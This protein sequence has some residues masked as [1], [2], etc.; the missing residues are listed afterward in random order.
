M[1]KA[2]AGRYLDCRALGTASSSAKRTVRSTAVTSP[3]LTSNLLRLAVGGSNDLM[4]QTYSYEAQ[5]AGVAMY[6][7][8]TAR[9]NQDER[10]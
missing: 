8:C 6:I 4:L 10:A 2:D 7:K 1:N 3:N 9:G 5:D